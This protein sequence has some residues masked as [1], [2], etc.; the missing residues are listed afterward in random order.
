MPNLYVFLF[1]F[2]IDRIS[3]KNFKKIWKNY[4]YRFTPWLA[5]NLAKKAKLPTNQEKINVQQLLSE[6]IEILLKFEAPPYECLYKGNTAE[7]RNI[8]KFC[9]E[10]NRRILQEKWGFELEIKQSKI[11]DGGR[12]VFV[13][14][15]YILPEFGQR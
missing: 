13:K 12:G 9:H 2:G 14:N 6:L 7:R 3:M 4:K 15:G 11:Q 10:R 5:L 1:I 8:F